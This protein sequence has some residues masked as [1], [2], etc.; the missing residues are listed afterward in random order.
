MSTVCL[1]IGAMKS[2]TSFIQRVLSQNKQQL[3]ESGHLFPGRRW[4]DQVL[5]VEEILDAGPKGKQRTKGAWNDLT[6]EIN[7]FTGAG[8]IV[9]MEGM[10]LASSRDAQRI[11]ESFPGHKVRIVVTARDLAR[12]VPAQWQESIKNG[13]TVD[14]GRYL[15]SSPFG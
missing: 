10:S 15:A 12:V 11:V 8:V 1:H 2:G 6:A 13:A 5:A 9:S 7:A 3:G 14:F 4:R